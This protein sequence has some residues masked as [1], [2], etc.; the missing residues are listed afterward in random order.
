AMHGGG[1]Y[2]FLALRVEN[3][4]LDAGA[5]DLDVAPA[6]VGPIHGV[7]NLDDVGVEVGRAP[8]MPDRELHGL[9]AVA[10]RDES[11]VLDDC[12][13]VG[14][15]ILNSERRLLDGGSVASD[16]ARCRYALRLCSR[17]GAQRHSE[18][19]QELKFFHWVFL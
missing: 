17:P 15:F 8:G 18:C 9:H 2:D 14:G 12:A 3:K 6:E 10:Q 1:L 4:P 13:F 11:R 5:A 7:A 19:E 16:D